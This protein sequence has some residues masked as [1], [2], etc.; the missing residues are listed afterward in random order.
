[1]MT[2]AKEYPF[3]I[4]T[5]GHIDH[6][7]TALVRAMTGV[8]CDRLSEEKRRGMTIEPG[9][10]ALPL[11]SGKTVSVIDV[12][13]HEKFIRQMTAGAAGVDAVMLVVAADDGVMP[14]TREHLEILS[15][16]GISDGLTVINKIDLVEPEMLEMAEEDVKELLRGT[17]LEDKPI[18]RASSVTQEGV[19]EILSAIDNM[20][21]VGVQRKREGHFFMPVDRAFH[22]AGFGTVVTGTPVKGEMLE[23]DDVEVMPSG[24]KTKIRSIQVH[25]E[26]AE[27][28]MAGRRTALS[29]TG[30]P[31]ED[32]ARGDSVTASGYYSPTSCI[33]VMIEVPP[34]FGEPIEH[35]RR[36]RLH[37]GTSDVIARVALLDGTKILPGEEAPAQIL[38][39]EPVTV[40]SG[41]RFILRNY[42]PLRTVAGGRVLL[43]AGERPKSKSEKKA[44]M[45]LLDG[46]SEERNDR[47]RLLAIT[48]Y[49]GIITFDDAAALLEIDLIGLNSHAS[50]LSAKGR[51]GVITYGEKSLI[52]KT[53][54]E[55]LTANLSKELDTFHS[56]HP[57]LTGM[58]L[59][60]AARRLGLGSGSRTKGILSYLTEGG[61]FIF[62][63]DKIRKSSFS[64]FNEE[65][66]EKKIEILRQK[67]EDA[68]YAMPTLEEAAAEIDAT[69]K[70]MR[71]I[72][73]YLKE[74][75]EAA[76]ITGGFLL[77]APLETDFIAKLSSIDGDITLAS[78]RDATGSSRKYI[79]PL[80]E[81]FDSKGITRRVG[82][83]RIIIKKQ[84]TDK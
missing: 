3:V 65:A 16:L 24:L 33:D 70:E 34:S 30:I 60:E 8:D 76:L 28:A 2:E 40:Y 78:A 47:K 68:G 37:A 38:T 62:D 69:D 22:V 15:L 63:G 17:F 45:A 25:G 42:S 84:K 59:E 41:E 61:T 83:K 52:S 19:A 49:R 73:D 32:I 27:R 21:S 44:L 23:G 75:K 46:L 31:L 20:I 7:K 58:E 81:Y 39:E 55:E 5:A 10:A 74:S 72:T 50:S 54:A 64:P 67:A 12:P 9:F 43:S 11:P 77:F 26:R 66:F 6:G 82:D 79:L 4:G 57:E 48:D 18:L 51:L 29:L 13:G 53:K 1:M 71:R 36:I 80:L 14:Q 35:W 56:E